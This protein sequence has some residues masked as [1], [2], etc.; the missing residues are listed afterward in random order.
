VLPSA[1]AGLAAD[2]EQREGEE[3]QADDRDGGSDLLA[4]FLGAA[5][6]EAD[7]DEAQLLREALKSM[8]TGGLTDVLAAGPPH[9]LNQFRIPR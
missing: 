1:V 7:R 8:P 6:T 3:R 2:R 4:H 5:V 9:L